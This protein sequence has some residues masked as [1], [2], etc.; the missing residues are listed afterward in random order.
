VLNLFEQP[1]LNHHTELVGGVSGDACGQLLRD[2]FAERRERYRQR[3]VNA[4]EVPEATPA[5]A[6]AEYGA[7]AIPAGEATEVELPHEPT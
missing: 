6:S 4:D 3:H 1:Q 5:A 7:L 2:F